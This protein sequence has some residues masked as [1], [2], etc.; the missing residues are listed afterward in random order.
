MAKTK[1]PTAY[2]LD[3]ST[4]AR[5]ASA[6]L[7]VED[8][9][10]LAQSFRERLVNAVGK[11]AGVRG[12]PLPKA[13]A[14]DIAMEVARGLEAKGY[15]GASLRVK[16]SQAMSLATCAPVLA[17]VDFAKVPGL[18]EGLAP[19]LKFCTA[20]KR[21]G[22]DT[23]KATREFKRKSASTKR[24]TAA[25][26]AIHVKSILSAKGRHP[27]VSEAAKKALR[28]WAAKFHIAISKPAAE[29]DD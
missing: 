17:T 12:K 11:L 18:S 28:A 23:A 29:S 5:L 6:I 13:D 22:F 1:E 14:K 4:R 16:Q 25:S 3:G 21:N 24:S 8:S 2:V 19:M 26:I 27:A 20:L 15:E 7:G 10:S 9:R